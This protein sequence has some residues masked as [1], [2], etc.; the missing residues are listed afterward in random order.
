MDKKFQNQKKE[1]NLNKGKLFD[2]LHFIFVSRT[3]TVIII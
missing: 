3:I 2:K 1:I